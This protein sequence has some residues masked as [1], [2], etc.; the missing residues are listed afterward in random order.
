MKYFLLFLSAT[1]L[2]SSCYKSDY[3]TDPNGGNNGGNSGTNCATVQCS[4]YT[5]NGYRCQRMTTNCN[6]RCWQ[7]Q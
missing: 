7:H 5:Q 3:Q 2:L 4:A 6:G 1:I